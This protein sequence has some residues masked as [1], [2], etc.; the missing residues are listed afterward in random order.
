MEA[1]KQDF[2]AMV[3]L[4]NLQAMIER[5]NRPQVDEATRHRL[6]NYQI[7]WNKCL[8]LLKPMITTLFA[9][10]DQSKALTDLLKQMAM[11][12]YLEPVRKGRK[13]SHTR[14]KMQGN[15]KHNNYPNYRHAI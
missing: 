5:A 14:R 2:H 3:F 12:R 13:F 10:G 6:H 7:D 15:C 11:T 9:Q 8:G 4:A 1:V